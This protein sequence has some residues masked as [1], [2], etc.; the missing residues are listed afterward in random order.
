MLRFIKFRAIQNLT[1]YTFTLIINSIEFTLCDDTYLSNPSRKQ[2]TIIRGLRIEKSQKSFFTFFCDFQ[3]L[4]HFFS[5]N[6]THEGNIKIEVL[7]TMMIRYR[8]RAAL[9]IQIYFI[10][11]KNLVKFD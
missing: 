4:I 1:S 5:S 3:H 2:Y 11:M 10:I 6:N 9:L 7:S 8:E